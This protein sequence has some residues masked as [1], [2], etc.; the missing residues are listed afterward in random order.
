MGLTQ[1]SAGA[2]VPY[3][4][5]GNSTCASNAAPV[6]NLAASVTKGTVPFAVTLNGSSSTA[7]TGANVAYYQFN[8]GDGTST[9]WQ[10]SPTAQHTYSTRGTYTASLQVADNRGLVSGSSN[11]L[12]I[13]AGPT[14]PKPLRRP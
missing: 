8:F 4:L 14:P 5:V 1:E 12:T 9:P 7:A 3:T 11:A 2:A 6:A 13:T 10:V